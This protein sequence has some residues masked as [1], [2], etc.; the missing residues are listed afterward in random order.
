MKK[1]KHVLNEKNAQYRKQDRT[2]CQPSLM[3]TVNCWES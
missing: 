3:S 1:K 2:Q